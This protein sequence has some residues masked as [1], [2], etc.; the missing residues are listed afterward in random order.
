[1]GARTQVG[2]QA[3]DGGGVEEHARRGATTGDDARGPTVGEAPGHGVQRV[4]AGARTTRAAAETKAA[5]VAAVGIR[6][7]MPAAGM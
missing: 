5:R 7:E 3:G 4:W 1:M 6:V 2:R